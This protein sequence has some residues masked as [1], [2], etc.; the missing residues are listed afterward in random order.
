[1]ELVDISIGCGDIEVACEYVKMKCGDIEV[2]CEYVKIK[3]GDISIKCVDSAEDMA[4]YAI[5]YNLVFH[6]TK[7]DR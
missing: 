4:P 3:C 5:S 2:A 1:M 6:D 7:Y